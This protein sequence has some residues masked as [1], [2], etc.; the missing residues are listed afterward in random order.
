MNSSDHTE[1]EQWIAE[2]INDI[3][4]IRLELANLETVI[5]GL[6]ALEDGDSSVQIDKEKYSKLLKQLLEDADHKPFFTVNEIMNGG[7]STIW[8]KYE[9]AVDELK[10][11]IQLIQHK[12][13]KKGIKS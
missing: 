5:D 8:E 13:E 2:H 11:D 7:L 9:R 3:W 10:N 12:L 1:A 4:K 6:P